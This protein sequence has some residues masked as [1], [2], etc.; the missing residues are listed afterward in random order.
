MPRY[1]NADKLRQ[2]WLENG[3]NEHVYDTNAFLDSIDN[4]PTADVAEVMHGRWIDRDDCDWTC[5]CCGHVS[6]PASPY[7]A[8]CGAKM[9][10]EA[11]KDV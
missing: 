3:E 11:N 1:I 4:Q 6:Q 9:D 7:C 10:L 5:S 2:E 8:W